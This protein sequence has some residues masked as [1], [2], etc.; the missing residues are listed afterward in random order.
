MIEEPLPL[1]PAVGLSSLNSELAILPHTIPKSSPRSASTFTKS[2]MKIFDFEYVILNY[3][4]WK[5]SI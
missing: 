3:E 2:P 5:K 1:Y 4:N